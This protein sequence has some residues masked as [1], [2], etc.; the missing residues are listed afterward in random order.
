MS[1]QVRPARPSDWPIVVDFNARLASETEGMELEREILTAGV[2]AALQDAGK[3]RYLVAC[4]GED[5]VGQL[6]HTQEWS[7]WRNGVIWWLQSVYVAPEHRS[8]GVFRLLF[9]ALRDM[10]ADDPE[11]VGLRLYVE[12]ENER[13][14]QVY[15]RLGFARGGYSVMQMFFGRANGRT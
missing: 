14:Q 10:A 5:V 6:M 12:N 1:Y 9:E 8:R 7:D 3:A 4:V 15:H 11:V 13:A 2:K